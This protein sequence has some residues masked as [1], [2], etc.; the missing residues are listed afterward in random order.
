MQARCRHD[1][2]STVTTNPGKITTPS[3]G[4]S[5]SG[6]GGGKSAGGNGYGGVVDKGWK[7][8][9]T[10]GKDG[11]SLSPGTVAGVVKADTYRVGGG[12]NRVG[13]QISALARG[14][15][16]TCGRGPAEWRKRAEPVSAGCEDR[17]RSGFDQGLLLV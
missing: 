14:W 2:A 3:S 4:S 11:F 8:V 5:G 12:P 17:L 15:P 1:P 13:G 9:K 7:L 10:L 6:S 16:T